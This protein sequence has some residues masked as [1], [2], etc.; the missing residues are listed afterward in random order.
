[1]ITLENF[2][3]TQFNIRT[4]YYFILEINIFIHNRFNK[5]VAFKILI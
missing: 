5:S 4:F 2:F 3:Y 1:M